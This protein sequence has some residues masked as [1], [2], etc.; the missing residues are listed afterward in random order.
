MLVHEECSGMEKHQVFVVVFCVIDSFR[1]QWTDPPLPIG[2]VL[3]RFTDRI[4]EKT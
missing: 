3:Q 2:A 1:L 4:K